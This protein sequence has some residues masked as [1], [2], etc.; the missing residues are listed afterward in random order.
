MTNNQLFLLLPGLFSFGAGFSLFWQILNHYDGLKSER[1]FFVLFDSQS[2]L[3]SEKGKKDL[4]KIKIAS[5]L[6]FIGVLIMFSTVGAIDNYNEEIPS[7]D[8]S[9]LP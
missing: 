1:T 3:R 2:P 7:S 4:H 6:M 8:G 9:V 5:L